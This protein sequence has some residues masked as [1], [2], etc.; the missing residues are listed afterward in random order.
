MTIYDKIF[1][2]G[3]SD[4]LLPIKFEPR[5]KTSFDNLGTIQNWQWITW[6]KRI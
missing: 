5:T 1:T 2:T 6:E 4:N 3:T